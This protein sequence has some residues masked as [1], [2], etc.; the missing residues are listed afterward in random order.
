KT[1]VGK[2]IDALNPGGL[3][4]VNEIIGEL[5]N[6]AGYETSAAELKQLLPGAKVYNPRDGFFTA[7]KD[8]WQSDTFFVHRKPL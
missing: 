4:I 7:D 5:G 8:D 6:F 3:L 1:A 2:A